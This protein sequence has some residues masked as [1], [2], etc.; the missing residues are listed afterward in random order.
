MRRL[1]PS[2]ILGVISIALLTAIL[3]VIPREALAQKTV[4]PV[5]G[6]PPPAPPAVRLRPERPHPTATRLKTLVENLRSAFPA[7]RDSAESELA[8]YGSHAIPALREAAGGPRPE[9]AERARRI[10]ERILADLVTLLDA[11]GEAIPGGKMEI[12]DG[13]GNTLE[14]TTDALG[15]LDIDVAGSPGDVRSLLAVVSHPEYGRAPG[16]FEEPDEP[17]GRGQRAEPRDRDGHDEPGERQERDGARGWR[18]ALVRTGSAAAERALSGRVTRPDGKPVAGAEVTCMNVRTSGEALINAGPANRV[19]TDEEGRFR[20]Y[21]ADT[22]PRKERGALIPPGSRFS[23]RVDAP[24]ALGLFPHA[25]EHRSAEVAEIRLERPERIVRLRFENPA[26]GDLSAPEALREVSL[27][28]RKTAGA[29]PLHLGSRPAVDGSARLAPGIYQATR[30]EMEYVPIEVASDGP[31]ELV[32]RLPPPIVYHGR[33]VDGATGAPLAGALVAGWTGTARDNL[34]LLGE[35]D[36]KALDGPLDIVSLDDPGLRA[37]R[38]HYSI[39]ALV[40][41]GPDGRFEILQGAGGKFYGLLAFARDRVPWKRR[42]HGVEVG[43]DRRGA[44]GDLP[45]FAAAKVTVEPVSPGKDVSVLPRWI[46]PKEKGQPAWLDRLL[47]TERRS[48]GEL[49]YVHWLRLGEAQPVFVPAGVR[50]RLRLETPYHDEWAPATLPQWIRLEPGGSLDLGPV[51]FAASLPVTVEVVDARG[52]PVEGIPVRGKHEDDG[53][54]CVAHV[55]D[56]RGLARFHVHPRS[57]GEFRVTDIPGGAG[58]AN[59][60]NL[61]ASFEVG[62]KVGSEQAP[63]RIALEDRQIEAIFKARHGG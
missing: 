10:L 36:W 11:T 37:L 27:T 51:A 23:I 33:V 4:G 2:A 56:A 50:L 6:P 28:Y 5:E 19:L 26:G 55:T 48:D 61:R 43:P 57:R 18:V 13:R 29:T 47:A 52:K 8:G 60:P 62:E 21:T 32:F 12:A 44:A 20:I 17:G 53:A 58:D 16:I 1:G 40:R 46:I 3:T 25:G 35:D 24:E 42:L 22:N 9:V 39:L 30:G 45:L 7:V 15:F 14:A 38:E 41:A 54:W 49:G 59:A 31:E 63:Y 34:A